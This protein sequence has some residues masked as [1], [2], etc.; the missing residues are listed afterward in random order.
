MAFSSSSSILL[1]MVLFVFLEYDK[2]AGHILKDVLTSW[3]HLMLQMI[4][5]E[6]VLNPLF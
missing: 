3:L 4:P 2:S 1:S 5:R 6:T